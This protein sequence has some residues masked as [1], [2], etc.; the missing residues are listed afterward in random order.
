MTA[1]KRLAC[2]CTL[3]PPCP[4]TFFVS[5]TGPNTL[6]YTCDGAAPLNISGTIQNIP[7][8][9]VNGFCAWST[10]GKPPGP[11][12]EP[13]ETSPYFVLAVFILNQWSLVLRAQNVGTPSWGLPNP[14]VFPECPPITD[15]NIPLSGFACGSHIHHVILS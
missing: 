15:A 2:C 9:L 13:C 5:V 10:D 12:P 4:D 3:C 6:C 8:V 11:F 14:G 1:D 7:G